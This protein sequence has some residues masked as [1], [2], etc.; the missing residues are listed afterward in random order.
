MQQAAINVFS[1]VYDFLLTSKV[2]RSWSLAEEV[3]A[4]PFSELLDH[5]IKR[6]QKNDKKHEIYRRILTLLTF[7]LQAIPQ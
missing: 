5:K 6:A 2:G 4:D 1:E 7:F 3:D